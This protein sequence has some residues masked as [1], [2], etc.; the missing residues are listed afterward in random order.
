MELKNLGSAK[1]EKSATDSLKDL[2][3]EPNGHLEEDFKLLNSKKTVVI[4]SSEE[5]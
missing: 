3:A 2:E 4:V 1:I 5:K